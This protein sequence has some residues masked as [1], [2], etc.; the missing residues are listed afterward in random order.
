MDSLTPE[1]KELIQS[2]DNKEKMVAMLAP[3]F[4]VDFD[5]PEIIG[6]L[7][8]LGFK[9]VAEVTRGA[10]ETNNQLLDLLKKNPEKRYIT[11]PCP[12]V[13]RLIKNKFP[14]LVQY[15]APIDSPMSATAKIVAKKWPKYKKVFIGPCLVKK[16]EAKEDWP[17]LDI[18]VLTYNEL[19]QIFDIKNIVPDKK[20]KKAKF[21]I[22]GVGTELYPISGGLAQSACLDEKLTDPEMD[23]ISGPVNVNKFLE[24]FFTEKKNVQVLDILNCDGGC[25]NGP[26][27]CSKEPLSTRRQKI[28]NYWDSHK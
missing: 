18:F 12:N 8:R 3:S 1:V 9:Y 15:L 5:Y 28:I 17:E 25:I 11:N 24:Q 10:I 27:V 16:L 22:V 13:V 23:I 19:K 4:A 14:E 20:D 7:K 2:I 6:M 21:D 26:G